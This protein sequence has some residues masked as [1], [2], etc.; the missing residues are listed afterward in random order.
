MAEEKLPYKRD[1]QNPSV[2]P[3]TA[4]CGS[5]VTGHLR[6]P[7]EN[8]LTLNWVPGTGHTAENKVSAWWD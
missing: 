1:T 8:K 5:V 7:G 4:T 6:T 3:P 2:A